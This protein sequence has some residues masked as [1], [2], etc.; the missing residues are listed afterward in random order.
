MAISTFRDDPTAASRY[1]AEQLTDSERSAYEAALTEDPDVLRE[2]E[3]T[4]RLKVG[5]QR[6]RDTGELRGLL[7]ES[8][9]VRLPLLV[10]LA[11]GLAAV[12][13]GIGVWHS[14]P[15]TARPHLL[16]AT[17][18]ALTKQVGEAVPLAGTEAVFR[19]RA[20]TYDVL[21][22]LPPGH[23]AV[24]LRVLP[25]TAAPSA[26]YR[27][28]LSRIGDVEAHHPV[29][30]LAGL[31]TAS[32]GFVEV[33]VDASELSPGTY[34]LLISGD[35]GDEAGATDAFLIKVVA[36]APR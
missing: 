5:L 29:A 26:H 27:I 8:R 9:F 19:K 28:T 11:A 2:L 35:A 4:A 25:E 3:A 22:S 20:A 1:L 18:G 24:E 13:I 31:K 33:F 23:A 15:D 21:L 6:L 17:L 10:A 36:P 14:N 34:R 30:A 7:R 32:D 12:V 16:A